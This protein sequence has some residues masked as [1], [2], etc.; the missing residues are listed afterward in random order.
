MSSRLRQ[1]AAPVAVFAQQ[2]LA[3]QQVVLLLC[4]VMH[5][6]HDGYTSAMY[7]L[8]PLIA[9]DLQLSFAQVGFLKTLISGGQ[10]LFQLP[11][12]FIAERLGER[13]M[14]SLGLAT[15]SGAFLLLSPAWSFPTVATLCL[16]IGLGASLQHPLSSSLVSRAYEAQGRRTAMGTYNF[17]GD[18]GKVAFPAL[19][20]GMILVLSWRGSV[21][22]LGAFGLV[23]AL[24]VWMSGKTRERSAHR[25]T[26]AGMPA[27][28][29]RG[30]GITD[31]RRFGGL[32]AVGMLDDSARAAFLTFVP[33]L[34]AQKGASPEQMGLLFTLVFAGGACGKFVCG[35][36]A[37]RLGAVRMVVVTE[38]LTGLSI[39]A[40][41][42]LPL[43]A[44]LVLLPVLGVFL[45][46]TSS[47]LY[48]TVAELVAP[49]ARTR[50]YGLF[51]ML[52]QGSGMIAPVLY[53]WLGDIAGLGWTMILLGFLTM[54][55][56]P[57]AVLMR[58]RKP[59]VAVS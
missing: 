18:V 57:L 23:A 4:C 30:W 11:G 12:G 51:Y 58:E 16:L 14:L 39:L 53:G 31:R 45:N 25:T 34:L 52:Y 3:Q 35:P 5:A 24:V 33:F 26:E 1:F 28:K 17:A 56:A 48:A 6:I 27:Q 8:L 36:L 59:A 22:L 15:L 54:G 43:T 2:G 49:E 40:L 47:V 7:L 38:L 37:E 42:P 29:P 9:S 10:S 21:E 13:R 19:L 44:S 55:A 46:G 50:G 41:L 32:V 20:T